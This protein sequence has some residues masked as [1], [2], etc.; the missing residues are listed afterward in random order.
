MYF[1]IGYVSDN[2]F[3]KNDNEYF[4]IKLQYLN[5]YLLI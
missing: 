5:F 4:E 2:F 3:L 1:S